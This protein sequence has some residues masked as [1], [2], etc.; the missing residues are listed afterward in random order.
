MTPADAHKAILQR[1]M[2]VWHTLVGG[3]QAAPTVPY[4]IDN[5]K[6]TQSTTFAHVAI[7][8]VGSEQST[9]GAE[10]RRQFERQGFID[11]RLF[12]PRD[13]GRG[14]LDTLAEYVRTIYEAKRIGESGDARGVVTYAMTVRELRNDAEYPDLWCL[15]CRVPFEYRHRR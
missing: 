11:V 1:W 9:L 3:S 5:R 6:V 13:Q 4:T 2:A 8:N 12:G 15:L 7:E 10:G 14:A